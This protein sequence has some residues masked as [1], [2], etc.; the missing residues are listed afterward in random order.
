[1]ALRWFVL[2]FP[3]VLALGCHTGPVI[4]GA[5]ERV[6]GR[7]PA[8]DENAKAYNDDVRWGRYYEASAQL[9]EEQRTAFLKL[10]EGEE[11]QYRFTSVDLIEATPSEDGKEV[12]MLVSLEFYRSPSVTEQ[13]VQQRQLWRFDFDERRWFVHPDLSVLGGPPPVGGAPLPATPAR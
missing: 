12:D 11:R 5:I 13:K 2:A 4:D 7:P 6:R 3:F 1:M 9:P 10:F 8:V